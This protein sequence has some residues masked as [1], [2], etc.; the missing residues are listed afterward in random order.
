MTLQADTFCLDLQTIKWMSWKND[1]N[2]WLNVQWPVF[3]NF[4]EKSTRR[5]Q[6]YKEYWKKKR[7]SPI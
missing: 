1:K 5:M 4:L 6:E 2:D 7:K 3:P